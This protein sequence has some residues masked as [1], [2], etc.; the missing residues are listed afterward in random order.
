VSTYWRVP[1]FPTSTDVF[2]CPKCGTYV[3]SLYGQEDMQP[4]EMS[5]QPIV[6]EKPSEEPQV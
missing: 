4:C 5:D 2:C 1:F 3:V 6:K